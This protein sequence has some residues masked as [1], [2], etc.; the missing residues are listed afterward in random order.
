MESNTGLMKASTHGS[1]IDGASGRDI[2][3]NQLM[4]SNGYMLIFPLS[5]V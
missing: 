4:A 1:D 5:V 3:V 2:E